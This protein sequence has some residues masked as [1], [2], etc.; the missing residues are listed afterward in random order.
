MSTGATTHRPS[1]EDY[2]YRATCV[3]QNAVLPPQVVCLSV[4]PLATSV[5]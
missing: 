4:R 5:G 2:V 3:I 1:S